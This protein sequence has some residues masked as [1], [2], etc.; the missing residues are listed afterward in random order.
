MKGHPVGHHGRGERHGARLRVRELLLAALLDGPAHGYELIRRLEEVSG[1]DWRPSPGSVYPN[2]QMLED[3]GLVQLQPLEAGRRVYAL[4]AA[5]RRRA[6]RG[7][8][9]V[10]TD[11]RDPVAESRRQLRDAV[12]RL[13]VAARQLGTSGS[14]EQLRRATEIVK[15][16]RQSLYAV[17]GED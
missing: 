3:E 2:L 15:A 14:D 7:E 1:G 5:G 8:M 6:D 10:L 16:A 17:L 11:S 4:T 9:R 13:A 12:D